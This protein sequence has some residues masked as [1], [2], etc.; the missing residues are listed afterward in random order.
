MANRNHIE[1]LNSGVES[2]NNWRKENLEIVP[3][4]AG[5][6]LSGAFL[7]DIYF[8]RADLAGANLSKANLSGANLGKANLTKAN[9][10]QANLS[11]AILSTANMKGCDL[12]RSHLRDA[13]LNGTNLEDA[14]L[15]GANLRGAFLTNANLIRCNLQ[16][17]KLIGANL[18]MARLAFADLTNAD[19]KEASCK[20]TDFTGAIFVGADM[21][22]TSLVDTKFVNADLI[23]C[24]IYG[25]NAWNLDLTGARQDNLIVTT[26]D[27][28]VVTVDDLEVAQFIYLLLNNSKI[29]NVINTI[30]SKAVLILGRFT[31]ERKAVLEALRKHLRSFDLLPILMDFEK[32]T[33]RTIQETVTTLA[34]LSRFIIADIT[35]PKSIPQELISIVQTLPSVPVQPLLLFGQQPWGMFESISIYPW[36]LP[37]FEYRD[38]ND[39]LLNLHE[40][41][42]K[43]VEAKVKEMEKK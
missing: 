32:P 26:A 4:L 22:R 18:N 20:K 40:K 17:A 31:S 8:G 5:L 28:P 10:N 38:I 25:I 6:N 36:V 29:R 34:R 11:N 21:E 41:V 23:N 12:I 35:E 24:Y 16:N 37:I 14:N 43:C 33:S 42:I 2:W 7:V 3:D 39:L 9:L 19:L 13:H 1:R 27:E 30:T 15:W